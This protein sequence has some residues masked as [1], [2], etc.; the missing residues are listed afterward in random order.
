MYNYTEAVANKLNG[1]LEKNY[2]AEKWYRTASQNAHSRSLVNFFERKAEERKGFG[3][4]LKNEIKSFGETP[5]KGGSSKGTM[6]RAW[7]NAKAFFASETD[8]AMLQEALRGEKAAIEEY[9]DV[10]NSRESL[11]QSTTNVLKDQRDAILNDATSIK[12][13]EDIK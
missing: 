10:I 8:E 2:D 6:H 11:P 3:Q 13:L 7:M 4:A 1:L 9:N 5:E 12:Q